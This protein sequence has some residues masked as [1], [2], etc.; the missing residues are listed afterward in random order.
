MSGL[1]SLPT[2]PCAVFVPVEDFI[3]TPRSAAVA[4]IVV[5]GERVLMQLRDQIGG[6]M[7]PGH[8]GLFGG[9]VEDGETLEECLARELEEELGLTG[10]NPSLFTSLS[11][12]FTFAG[13]GRITRS[14]YAIAVS[15]DVASQ[16]RLGEG[17]AMAQFS[18]AEIL[19][20]AKVMP[21]DAYALW[22][23]ANRDRLAL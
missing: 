11:Y 1:P 20:E 13:K 23:Y 5:D 6:I 15:G 14:Y 8:W 16:L 12:D 19:A 22:L 7:Y 18:P 2:G 3:F 10:I 17:A 21:F 9:A 4:I